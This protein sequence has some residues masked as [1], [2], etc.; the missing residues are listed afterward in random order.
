MGETTPVIME[1]ALNGVTRKDQNPA[2]PVLPDEI[3]AD[4]LRCLDAGAAIVHTHSD[5]PGEAPR[6]IADRYLEAYEPILAQRSDAILYPTVG[7]GGDPA[8]RF[9]HQVHL[10]AAGAI[11]S[12]ILDPGS[13]N[14][15]ATGPDGWPVAMDFVYVNT[16]NDIR[17]MAEICEGERLGPSIAIFEPGFLRVVVAAKRAH[18]LPQGALVKFYFSAGGYLGAGEPIFSPPPIREALD[19]YL[20][21]LG[22]CG[23]PWAVAVLG[24]SVFDTEIAALALDR[25]GHLRVGL[26]DAQTAESNL[27]EVRRGA[28]LARAHG[29]TLAS[30]AETSKLLN[31]PRAV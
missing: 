25:G 22:D 3:A 28:A 4:A 7:F 6:E 21:M 20:A 10:A 9:D 23:L 29:R 1:V 16:P 11:R 12:G 24:G 8:A 30:C 26:E 18:A 19:L 31:L 13:V 15:G 2:A 14:L 27:A 17:R 5:T